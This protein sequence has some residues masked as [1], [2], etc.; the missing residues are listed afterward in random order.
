[1]GEGWGRVGEGLGKGVALPLAQLL[2]NGF[3][4]AVGVFQNVAIPEQHDLIALA[5]KPRR[6]FGTLCDL[7]SMSSAV[8]F[9][10]DFAL[11][12]HE[13]DNVSPDGSLPADAKAFE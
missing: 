8:N 12:T 9:D 7:L 1:M 10:D 4:D 13:V 2:K 6:S 5:L 3:H 11:R